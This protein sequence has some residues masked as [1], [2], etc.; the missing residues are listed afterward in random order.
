MLQQFFV[1]Y[2]VR[3]DHQQFGGFGADSLV[4]V[5]DVGKDPDNRLPMGKILLAVS[6]E[7]RAHELQLGDDQFWIIFYLAL[8][9]QKFA[10]HAGKSQ[11]RDIWQFEVGAVGQFLNLA[12]CIVEEVEQ[13]IEN[14]FNKERHM[15]QCEANL[16]VGQFVDQVYDFERENSLFGGDDPGE[17]LDGAHELFLGLDCA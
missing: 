16:E 2:Q 5:F 13:F 6:F 3:Y 1:S 10:D 15:L 9:A 14:F 17:Q 12:I 11:E 8:V 4:G 7:E